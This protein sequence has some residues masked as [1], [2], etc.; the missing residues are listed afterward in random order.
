MKPEDMNKES[1]SGIV[2]FSIKHPHFIIV[3]CLISV[4]LGTLS[5]VLLPKDLLPSANMPA[6]QILSFYP[7]MPVD[8]VEQDM[9]F[10]FERYTGQAVGVESQQSRSLMGMSIVKNFFNSSIDL[11]SAIAQTGSF[12]TSVM[13][14]LPPGTQPPLILPF[15]PMAS[16]PLA[17]VSVGGENK[18]ESQIADIARFWVTNGIQSVPGAMAP[19]VMGGKTRQAIIYLDEQKLREYNFSPV[20]VMDR[21]NAMNTFIPAGDIKI[22]KTDYQIVSNGLVTNLEDMDHFLLRAENG[23]PIPLSLVGQ[24][25]DSHAIQTNIVEIDGKPQAYVPIYRQ[26]G[27]NSLLIVDEV[28]KTMS[29]LEKTLDG[30]KLT[31]VADQSIFIR[32]AIESITHEALIGG[33]FAAL[34]VLLFLGSWRATFAVLLSLPLSLVGAFAALKM[35]GQTLNVMTLGGLALSVGV[36]VDN[37]IV[38]IEVIMQKMSLGYEPRRASLIG[39]QEVAMPVLASTVSTLIVFFPIVFLGGVVKVLLAALSVAVIAAMAASYFAAMTVIP[40]F[41]TYFLKKETEKKTKGFLAM[42]QRWLDRVTDGYINTLTMVL[43]RPKMILSV[44]VVVLLAA[45]AIFTPMIGAELFPRADAGGFRLDMRAQAGLR[46]EE[47][48]K[49][50]EEIQGRLRQWID[51]SDLKMI[52]S[53]AGIYYGYAAA[54]SPN[55]G[56]QDFFLNV[57]LTEDRKHTSQYYAQII[58]E[59]LPKEFPQ[60]EFGVELGGLLSSA[61]SQGLVSPID[62]QVMGPNNEKSHEIA[63]GVLPAIKKIPG[64]VDV[65][66]QQKLD[67]PQINLN[68]DRAKARDLGLTPDDVVK[69]VVSGVVNS[70]TYSQAMWIDPKTGI[71]Y[72]LGVQ[73]PENKMDNMQDLLNIPITGPTH[74]RSVT[75]G[76]LATTSESKGATEINHKNLQPVIDIFLDAQ[77]RDI[78]GVSNDVQKILDKVQFPKGYSVEIRGEISD[79][80]TA[81][82]QL[83]GGFLLAALLVYLILVVQFKS[84]LLP[85]IIMTTVPMGMVGIIV[86]LALTKTYFSI[87]AAIGGIFVIGVAVSHGVLLVEYILEV[88]HSETN[89]KTAIL[90]AARARLRPITMTSLASILGLLPMAMGMGQG[91]EA[92]I[93]LGRAVIGGQILATLLNFYLVPALFLLLYRFTK[94]ENRIEQHTP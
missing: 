79:M 59:R 19:A 9:T 25:K 52:I 87:Q 31:I 16:V 27:A 49:L 1:E 42:V 93:P 24:A 51:P 18:T 67:A 90:T 92:N 66:I 82:G 41:T 73:F 86:I 94:A 43:K 46:V 34:M 88:S 40:L 29:N 6:V 55:S 63:E 4:V 10:P 5:L 28:A 13:R 36:L 50:S 57:E 78:A 32:K 60:V 71:D 23:V 80:K 48:N 26:P 75:L 38:V 84:F 68:I 69:N 64:A 89:L 12:A 30:F 44:S 35:T 61:I 11:S 62:V 14:K 81:I 15:D 37:A 83:G 20:Q 58:R 21:L 53:N 72:L 76:A 3:A 54:F 70:A 74:K 7:G 47:T 77:G 56:S 45:A 22:G 2:A 39:G 17:M 8:H 85:G 33:G 65:R 91:S